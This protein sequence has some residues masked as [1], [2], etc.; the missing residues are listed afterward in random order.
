MILKS[1]FL[2]ILRRMSY[3]LM[4]CEF[5]LRVIQQDAIWSGEKF[6]EDPNFFV[7]LHVKHIEDWVPN[8]SKYLG[9]A[10]GWRFLVAGDDE[11]VW[12]D[13]NILD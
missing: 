9:L 4:G 5:I 1:V 11:D 10:P 13:H 12:Y 3:Q 8:I 7:P 2:K 6:W